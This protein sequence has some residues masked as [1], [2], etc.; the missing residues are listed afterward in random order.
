MA[1]YELGSDK[2][3]LK[4]FPDSINKGRKGLVVIAIP[5]TVDG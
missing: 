2:V 5:D 3:I 4:E 1:N